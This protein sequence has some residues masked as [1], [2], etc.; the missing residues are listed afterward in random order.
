MSKKKVDKK[1][2]FKKYFN[3]K[4]IL[5]LLLIVYVVVFIFNIVKPLPENISYESDVYQIN[6]DDVEFLYDLTYKNS[7]GEIVYEQEIFDNIFG[8]I[9]SADEYILLDMF[10]YNPYL[11]KAND[12]YLP[13][14]SMLTDR[15]AEK[16]INDSNI[17]I[18][19]ITDEINIVYGGY[20]SEQF[21]K[22]KSLGVNVIYT[23]M[24]HLRD[25]NP[26]YSTLWRMFFI[27]FGNS[28]NGS[29]MKH[30]FIDGEKVSLRSYLK[31]ANFK[32]NHRKVIVAD[33]GDSYSTIVT[34]ANPHDGS[35]AHS[36]VALRVNGDFAKEVYISEKAVSEN[37]LSV[38]NFSS[39]NKAE[40]NVLN[41]SLITESKIR[42]SIIYEVD[43]LEKGDKIDVGIFYIS[44]RKVVNSLIDASNRG[45]EVR[46]V[47]DP[48]KDAFGYEKNGVPNRPVASELIKDSDGKIKVKWYGTNGEQFHT[49]MVHIKKKNGKNILILGSSNYTKRNLGDLNLEMNV[50]VLGDS[51]SKLFKDVD[52]YFNRIWNNEDGVYTVSYEE[53]EDNSLFRYLLYRFQEF[54][55]LCTF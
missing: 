18:D 36:N 52:L 32:A 1:N 46:I 6:E 12:S 41:V 55:G 11:G 44:D 13:L 14:S 42:D 54:T 17:K 5:L 53:Y 29:L 37:R 8:V 3:Y 38:I 19:L 33:N 25:S 24:T 2:R 50:K 15:I 21:E 16:K 31:L 7:D 39:E 27:W 34:S 45:V 23:D 4:N 49:K 35:S 43:K 9:D 30:P 48:N 22:L 28:E 20:E 26:I 10:L 47:L 40:N 51:D